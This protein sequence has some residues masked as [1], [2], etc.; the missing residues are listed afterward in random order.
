MCPVYA[1]ASISCCVIAVVRDRFPYTAYTRQD[2]EGDVY[3][4][5]SYDLLMQHGHPIAFRAAAARLSLSILFCSGFQV[6]IFVHNNYIMIGMLPVLCG[7]DPYHY[8]PCQ[9]N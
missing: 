8:Y 9:V 2:D 1:I 7:C 6:S 3:E 5:F 4:F